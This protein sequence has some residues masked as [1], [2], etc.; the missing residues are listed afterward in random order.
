MTD[1]LPTFDLAVKGKVCGVRFHAEHSDWTAAQVKAHLMELQA[2][3][4]FLVYEVTVHH[5]D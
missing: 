2:V 1:T 4:G 5:D 3:Q